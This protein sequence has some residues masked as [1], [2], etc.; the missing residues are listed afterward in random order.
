MS[1]DCKLC[2][3]MRLKRYERA[4]REYV[5]ARDARDACAEVK[6]KCSDPTGPR[7]C[8]GCA[9]WRAADEMLRV[10]REAL[11]AMAKGER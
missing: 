3:K 1:C 7:V 4:V 5:E 11:V 6:C 10:A 8:V 9:T 2:L